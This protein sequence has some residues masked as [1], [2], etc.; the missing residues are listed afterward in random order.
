MVPILPALRAPGDNRQVINRTDSSRVT[1]VHLP[2]WQA[3]VALNQAPR[4]AA[5][6]RT[7]AYLKVQLARAVAMIPLRNWKPD[8]AR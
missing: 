7:A 4:A 6:A 8:A 2:R 5:M 1:E 3:T